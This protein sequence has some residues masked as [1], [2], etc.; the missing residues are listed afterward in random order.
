[1]SNFEP[2]EVIIGGSEE[3]ATEYLIQQRRRGFRYPANSYRIVTEREQLRDIN[4]PNSVIV[5]LPGHHDNYAFNSAE[6]EL[7]V[8]RAARLKLA[9]KF[10]HKL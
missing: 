7:L 5:L 9:R 8:T 6:Y 4:V 3:M 10:V 1:M 2:F